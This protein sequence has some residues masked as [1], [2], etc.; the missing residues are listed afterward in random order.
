MYMDRSISRVLEGQ[1]G[2]ECAKSEIIERPIVP[3]LF[4]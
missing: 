3:V 1:A 4:E 2:Y